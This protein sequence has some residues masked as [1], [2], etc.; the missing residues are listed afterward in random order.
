MNIIIIIIVI[1]ITTIIIIIITTIIII[2]LHRS[3]PPFIQYDCLGQELLFAALALMPSGD[4][5]IEREQ[6]STAAATSNQSTRPLMQS[7]LSSYTFM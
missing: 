2:I 6:M 7:S 1:I 4:E 3:H 5:S